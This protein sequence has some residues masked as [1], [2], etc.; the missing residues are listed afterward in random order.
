MLIKP[1]RREATENEIC[2][3]LQIPDLCRK[4]RR[5]IEMSLNIGDFHADDSVRHI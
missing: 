1:G 4:K 5:N 3:T 2:L